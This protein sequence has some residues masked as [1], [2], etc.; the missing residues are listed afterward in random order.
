MATINA[1]NGRNGGNNNNDTGTM[2][3]GSLGERLARVKPTRWARFGVVSLLFVAWIIWLGSWWVIV[4][5]PLLADIYLTQFIPWTWWKHTKNK[6]VRTVMSWVDA[7]VYALI[8]VYFLF[9]FV[10]QNYQIPSSSLEKI[11]RASCRERV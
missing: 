2:Q 1:Q 3:S 11:G 6:A 10:G 9:I 8:L 5:W 4:F 7:I